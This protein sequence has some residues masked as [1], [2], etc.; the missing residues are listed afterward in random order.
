MSKM[1]LAIIITGYFILGVLYAAFTPAWQAPDEP[2]HYNF[3]RYVAQ[4]MTLPE[5]TMGCYDQTY[6]E[7]LKSQKFPA[8]LSITPVCYEHYQPPLY[9]LLAV[10]VFRA[11]GGN[12]FALRLFSVIL[13]GV[14]LVMVYKTVDLFL[15]QTIFPLATTAFVAFGPMHLTMM[16][17][18]NNDSLAELLFI[19][20]SYLL[21]RW[22]LTGAG[23]GSGVPIIAGVVLGLILLTKV[24]IYTGLLLAAFVI[25]LADRRRP[26]LLKNGL[27]LYLPALGIALPLYLRNALLYGNLDVLGL[28]RHDEVVVG[29][30]RTAAKLSNEGT[31][32]YL[33]DLARTTFHSF[34]GQF[35]W[36][37]VPMDS[38]VYLVLTILQLVALG[39]LV[40]WWWQYRSHPKQ[41]RQGLAV[42]AATLVLVTGVFVGLNLSFVQ[43]QGRYFF[44]ALMPLGLF[45]SLGLFE[46]F[47]RRYALGMAAILLLVTGWVA[48]HS[49]RQGGLDKWGLL[50][51]GGAMVAF[52]ARRWLPAEA[53]GWV[54]GG[55]YAALAGLAGVSLWWFIVPNL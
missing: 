47:R 37:A 50:I 18:V 32:T 48:F 38:R 53:S 33:N 55:V 20:L 44:S 2:A 39:G 40:L 49:I 17:S 42:M 3:V 54:V 25:F 22:L 51:S 11:T 29:Q 45:F 35:G 31:W 9:Y 7:Q 16:A 26:V 6:L 41:I 21:L 28:R 13:G 52:L 24:T 27:R 10:P 15:P 23:E 43:F 19:G 4:N 30:L 8:H 46:A 34:W 5:L 12:L 36:M 14:A 1:I